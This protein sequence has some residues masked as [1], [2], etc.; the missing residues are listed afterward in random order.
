ML[1]GLNGATT[2]R[3]DL[4]TDIRVARGAGYTHLEVWAAKLDAYLTTGTLSALK[5]LLAENG[6]Q[7]VSINAVENITF[8]PPEKFAHVQQLCATLCER[9]KA[10]GCPFVIVV[11]SPLPTP[12]IGQEEIRQESIAKLTCLLDIAKSNG[13]GLA[14]EFLGE[15]ACSVRTLAFANEIVEAIGDPNLGL[16][17]DTFHFYSGGSSLD[18]ISQVDPKRLFIVHLNDS[19]D[20]PLETLR[21]EHR[22]L[23]GEGVIPL[24]D[25]LTRLK[26]I[27]YQGVYSIELFRPEY[28]DWEPSRLVTEAK[29]RMVSLL[30]QVA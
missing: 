6:L 30:N 23:P 16:V 27:A 17:L 7:A 11:P 10:I 26:G 4:E 22:L 1:L 14:F 5:A 9:A 2:I 18:S 25:I 12:S 20:M 3:A 29:A 15:P 19:E 28:Y 13:V 24:H 8:Q 21:D